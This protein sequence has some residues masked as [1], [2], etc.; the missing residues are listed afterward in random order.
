MP[1][2]PAVDTADSVNTIRRLL[3]DLAVGTPQEYERIP[4]IWKVAIDAGKRNDSTELTQLLQQAVPH[5]DQPAQHWQVVVIGGG[6]INGLTLTGV[7]P[8]QRIH[9]LLANDAQLQQRWSRLL[10]LAAEMADDESVTVGTR[11]DAL[12]ILGT[13]DLPSSASTLA[14][15]LT[16]DT[17][18]LQLGAISALGD[19][20]GD[21]AAKVLIDNFGAYNQDNMDFAIEALLRSE[22]RAAL[23]LDSLEDGTISAALLT[24]AQKDRILSIQYQ[25]LRERA[26]KVLH[27]K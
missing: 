24:Q 20:E 17:A 19:I 11:Y 9:S 10:E 15:Y 1:F 18:D 3:A 23:F 13:D 4:A 2:E 27:G 6:I 8:A 12:R 16:H 21:Q 7:W 25:A 14:A 26:A 5:L 22:S